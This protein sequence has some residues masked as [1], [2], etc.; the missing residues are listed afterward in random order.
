MPFAGGSPV[1][2]LQPDD[3]LWVVDYPPKQQSQG[4]RVMTTRLQKTQTGQ[5]GPR[6]GQT[7]SR[8]F[9]ANERINQMILENLDS[10]A[11]RAQLHG[12]VRTIAAIVTHMHNIRCKWIRLTAPHLEVPRQL[13]RAHCTQR[14]ARARL[15]ESASLCC[16][17]LE[18]AL[19][20]DHGR[21]KEFHRDGWAP[22]WPVGQ[23]ML[24]Y[25]LVHEAH[26]RGQISMLAHQLGFPLPKKAAYGIWNWERLI[27]VGKRG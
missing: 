1:L 12:K 22:A 15:A 14:Q 21:I 27:P 5:A 8:I 11:W 6:L 16:E 3:K 24:C 18:Q 25:M 10:A 13:H 4:L 2:S 19:G 26:H 7:A 20:A 9:A 23:E 17:M